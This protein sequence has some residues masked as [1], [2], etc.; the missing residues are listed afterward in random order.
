[1][2]LTLSH[3]LWKGKHAMTHRERLIAALEHRQPDRLPK[4]LGTARFTGMVRRAYD[5]LRDHLGFGAPGR[6]VDRMQQVVEMDEAILRYFDTDARSVSQGAP[7]RA[8]DVELD[9]ERYRDEWGVIRRLSPGGEY[10]ELSTSPL[11]GRLDAAAIARHRWPD[12]T[13][14]GLTRGLRER[15][16]HLRNTTDYAIIYNARYN[17][18]HQTQYLRGFEDWYCDLAGQH[19]LFNGL[20]TAVT[21]ILIEANRRALSEIGDLID[22]VAF[23][24]DVGLQDRAICSLPVYRRLIRPYHERALDSARSLTSAKFLYHSCGSTYAYMNDFIEM[25][26]HAVNPVQV[27]ARNMDPARLKREFGDRLT[28]WGGI[29]SQHVLPHGNPAAVKAEVE[30]MSAIMGAGGGYVLAAVHNIQPDVPPEN[31]VALFGPR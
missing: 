7:D 29:D 5:R 16:V 11:A 30:R 9:A 8:A 27:T 1:M 13:D 25:G 23:G 18:V 26:I 10:C 19:D 4:D 15:A 3:K 21:E 31:I 6:I 24:D 14:P 28:F 20:M 22:V 17:V 2:P 12:P